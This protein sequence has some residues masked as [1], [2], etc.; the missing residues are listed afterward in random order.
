MASRRVRRGGVGGDIRAHRLAPPVDTSTTP[1]VQCC[2]RAALAARWPEPNRTILIGRLQAGE[3]AARVWPATEHG[4]LRCSPELDTPTSP[5]RATRSRHAQ[6][7][8]DRLHANESDSRTPPGGPEFG[9]SATRSLKT[10]QCVKSQCTCTPSL[11]L[12]SGGARVA[13]M[14]EDG[15]LKLVPDSSPELSLDHDELLHGSSAVGLAPTLRSLMESLI[16]AQDER[17]RR[18]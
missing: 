2:V 13:C 12:T 16:L 11:G 1:V 6:N 7:G 10:A 15:C 8:A 9:R 5:T 18:A 4:P 3:P 17:W 14:K